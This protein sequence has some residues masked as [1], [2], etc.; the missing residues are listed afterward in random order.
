[1][2]LPS[3]LS[4]TSNLVVQWNRLGNI[5]TNPVGLAPDAEE[6]RA[7]CC[8]GTTPHLSLD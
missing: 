7:G 2:A 4:L 1:V 8:M 5:N 3:D 6:G